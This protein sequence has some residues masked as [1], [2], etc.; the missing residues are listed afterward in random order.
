MLLLAFSSAFSGKLGKFLKKRRFTPSSPFSPFRTATTG[1][2]AKSQAKGAVLTAVSVDSGAPSSSSGGG[3][4]GGAP[5]KKKRMKPRHKSPKDGDSVGVKRKA[6]E[7][8]LQAAIVAAAARA[9]AKAPNSGLE[10]PAAEKGG[11]IQGFCGAF[12]GLFL[13]AGAAVG[14]AAAWALGVLGAV[15][16]ASVLVRLC[17]LCALGLGSRGAA[18]WLEL[19]PAHSR[20]FYVNG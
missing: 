15:A 7:A 19:H 13:G 9:A 5:A 18:S 14:S 3:G 2:Q 17:A 11:P 8:D 6:S 1:G 12:S 4:G 10:G 16:C 20:A